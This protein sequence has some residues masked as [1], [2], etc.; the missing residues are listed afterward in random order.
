VL[1]FCHTSTRAAR[2]RAGELR[3]I[4]PRGD[5]E[6]FAS[7]CS[8][9]W[10]AERRRVLHDAEASPSSRT[11]SPRSRCTAQAPAISPHRSRPSSPAIRARDRVPPRTARR[12][13]ATG[14]AVL[15]ALVEHYLRLVGGARDPADGERAF[16]RCRGLATMSRNGPRGFHRVQSSCT[17][18]RRRRVRRV[19]G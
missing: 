8:K 17:T 6:T 3:R 7:R 9:P 19:P 13:R 2:D 5:Q 11:V 18:L 4:R 1:P 14:S 12:K 15:P 10:R 16:R